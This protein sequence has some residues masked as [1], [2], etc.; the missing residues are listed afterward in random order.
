ML[1]DGNDRTY[2]YK[3]FMFKNICKKIKKGNLRDV[4]ENE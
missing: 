4:S 3:H 1:Y 2:E